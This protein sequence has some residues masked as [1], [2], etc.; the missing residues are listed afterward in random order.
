MFNGVF[1][2]VFSF[3]KDE[4]KF[5]LIRFKTLILPHAKN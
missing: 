2:V 3:S 1:R 4:N 5:L